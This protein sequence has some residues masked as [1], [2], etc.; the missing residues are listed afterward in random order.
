MA[1]NVMKG[2][3]A[4]HGSKVS[5]VPKAVDYDKIIGENQYVVEL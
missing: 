5:P 1:S 4:G 2:K 3:L